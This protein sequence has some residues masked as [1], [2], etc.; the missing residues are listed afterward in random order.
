MVA[1]GQT[2]LTEY[3]NVP[4]TA[5]SSA[6][7]TAFRAEE[8]A[9]H[10]PVKEEPV[11]FIAYYPYAAEVTDFIYPIA[12]ADQSAS[13]VAHDLM[14]ARADNQGTGYTY[15][16]VSFAFTHQLSRMVLNITDE[17]EELLTPDQVTLRGMYTNGT[18]D[19]STGTL[20]RNATRGDILPY[21][22]KD[23]YEA[24]LI[25]FS[26]ASGHEV[27]IDIAG[28]Q[29]TWTMQESYGGL[30]IKAGYSYTFNVTVHTATGEVEA[31]LIDFNGNSV[32]PWG[33]NGGDHPYYT[34]LPE[35]ENDG[36][37]RAFPGAEGGGMFTTG[38]RGGRVIKVTR[39]EDDEQPGSLRYAIN[40]SSTRTIV[41]EV[42]G[43]IELQKTLEIKN[44]NV[45][46]AG[47]TAPGD[48]I[49]LKNYSLV[50]KSDNVIIR[51][52][53]SRMG[54]EK[55]TEDDAM[56]GRYLRN[57]IID[58]CSMSWS[59]DECSSF[60]ANENF[61]MQWCILSESLR[62]STHAKGNHGY[63]A[64]WG[65]VN[66]SFHH[67]LLAHH[68]SRN[69]RFDGGDVYGISSN[70]LNNDQR[71]VDFRNCVVYNYSN[72]PAYGG[73]A[74][75]VNFVGNYYKWGPGSINGPDAD[76]KGK[77]REYFYF[78]SGV[79]GDVDYGC[80]SIYLD[81]TN[82]LD[83]S[84]NDNENITKV[85]D[86]NWLGMEYDTKNQGSTE[87]TPLST[88]VRITPDGTPASVTYH[89]T[90]VAFG[91][92][93]EYAGAS[94]KRDA[95][96]ERAVYDTRNGIATCMQGSNGSLNGYIDSPQDVG[97]WP[98]YKQGEVPED[99]DGDGIPDYWEELYGLDK[100]NPDDGNAKTLD[101]SGRYTNLE[102]YLHDLVKDIVNGQVQNGTYISL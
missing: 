32:A 1:S 57:V 44:G 92:V 56:W 48:G 4:Y 38:G 79:K 6:P 63:G 90:D 69:P 13:L 75:K 7:T 77:K 19:L 42:D 76:T 41:F 95:V 84:G 40:Q 98:T 22:Y 81:H 82:Y 54:D 52:I 9:I 21:R 30:E 36:L 96:D 61:T 47:Q 34:D 68:D 5:E 89:P 66:A 93:L 18:F 15:G 91:K 20:Q 27:A 25:P 55:G 3:A 67:N 60:Y 29:Y 87:Y 74:Q 53:R 26:F 23:T 43:V 11:D 51:F 64:I 8:V 70:P 2:T 49:C 46:I 65:G 28:K 97:G 17:N 88:P 37:I 72:Y 71:A 83:T 100:D 10:Y 24:I 35:Y 78:I 94:L 62:R 58:H 85:N 31:I 86:N 39:L 33:N 80:P 14:Y 12:L 59:T 99:S 50:V 101:P 45:T 102:I 16:S 73:E